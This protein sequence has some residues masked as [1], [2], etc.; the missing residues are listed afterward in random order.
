MFVLFVLFVY[1]VCLP[2]DHLTRTA[3]FD[4]RVRTDGWKR[5]QSS[6]S[7][8]K[9]TNKSSHLPAEFGIQFSHTTT[10]FGISFS[11]CRKGKYLLWLQ[12]AFS[13][14]FFYGFFISYDVVNCPQFIGD[15]LTVPLKTPP[16]VKSL[17]SHIWVLFAPI[18]T[19]RAKMIEIV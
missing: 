3:Q 6:Q 4:H 7:R 19:Y 13:T 11:A 15:Y 12:F 16:L 14:N 8:P 5:H 9:V 17:D 10:L 2:D 18:H 1:L